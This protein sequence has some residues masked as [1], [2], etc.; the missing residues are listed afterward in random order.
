MAT[1]T[2]S[3]HLSLP[4]FSSKPEEDFGQFLFDFDLACKA[5]DWPDP[6]QDDDLHSDDLLS[7]TYADHTKE[8]RHI[9]LQ[10]SLRGKAA[11]ILLTL[12][13]DTLRN[14]RLLRST[15]L[16]RFL[17]VEYRA[18]RRT[19]LRTRRRQPNESLSALAAD[20]HITASR[21]YPDGND[22]LIND[23]AKDA[24][25]DSLDDQLRAK[26][27]DADPSDLGAA[28]RRAMVAEANLK[29]LAIQTLPAAAV[30]HSSS[31]RTHTDKV[32]E[33]I[34]E[35]LSRLETKHTAAA[36]PSPHRPDYSAY[37][38]S[39]RQY[40]RDSDRFH[41][42]QPRQ[43]SPSPQHMPMYCTYCS[44]TG[45]TD[46]RCWRKPPQP[47]PHDRY[48]RSFSGPRD[49]PDSQTSQRY[50]PRHHNSP[51]TPRTLN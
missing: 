30:Q 3:P 19:E 6:T 14:Y 45:H 8:K 41:S 35:R 46:S 11:R 2:P 27:L 15:L 29:R 36:Q 22:A 26:V 48:Q 18:L 16:H 42:Y 23:L 32:L 33:D 47:Y 39:P 13:D 44:R 34:V 43:R 21:A 17:P 9:M 1:S 38:A 50:N 20:I 10:R 7:N 24:F 37:R 49:G 31:T 12:D 5:N 4:T 25:I 28:L 51:R 40:S